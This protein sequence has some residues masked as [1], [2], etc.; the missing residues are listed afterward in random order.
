MAVCLSPVA[1]I[2]PLMGEGGGLDGEVV[3]RL[4]WPLDF[5]GGGSSSTLGVEM[6]SLVRRPA[7]VEGNLASL[8]AIAAVIWD[9]G[10]AML[11]HPC[12]NSIPLAKYLFSV[13]ERT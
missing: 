11:D 13:T 3:G 7:G 10:Q 5:R 8:A 1:V 4:G 12:L 2:A 6:D 9:G